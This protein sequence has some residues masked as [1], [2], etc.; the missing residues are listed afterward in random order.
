M[1]EW[2]CRPIGSRA[3]GRPQASRG[4]SRRPAA[5]A[6][7]PA[8]AGSGA[9]SRCVSRE[10]R[11]V[12]PDA[13][14]L[15]PARRARG[16]ARRRSRLSRSR[17]RSNCIA[18]SA[19]APTGTARSAASYLPHLRNAIY[20]HLIAAHIALDEAEG[21]TGPGALLE[22]GDFN[23]DAR[24]EV[25]LENDRLVAFVRP[26]TRRPCLRFDVRPDA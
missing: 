6:V 3:E 4:P 15:P 11:D 21:K 24:Q 19:T 17:A 1:T 18:A 9:T 14:H 22:V 26:A 12:R 20:H 2:R 10:R 23:L 16:N 5:Q 13:R 8:P 25:R 7:R